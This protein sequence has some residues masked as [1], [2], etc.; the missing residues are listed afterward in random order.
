MLEVKGLFFK[1]KSQDIENKIDT[2]IILDFTLLRVMNLNYSSATIT[3][4]VYENNN[5]KARK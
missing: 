3:I 2:C 1:E 5:L 4:L